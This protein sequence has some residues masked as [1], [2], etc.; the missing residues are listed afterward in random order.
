[1][2]TFPASLRQAA[3]V[4]VAVVVGAAVASAQAPDESQV[5]LP[6]GVTLTYAT[7]GDPDGEP[8]VLVAGTGMQ[9]VD[10]PESLVRGLVERGFRVI[11]FDNRDVG[12]V[13][14][15]RGRP[16]PDPGGDRRGGG[17]GREPVPLLDAGPGRG[18]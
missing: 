14:R 7:D 4:A 18:R 10:W 6:S 5:T 13:D 17:R 9:L 12:L 15:L 8:L 3:A 1:M 2:H 16:R 11:R